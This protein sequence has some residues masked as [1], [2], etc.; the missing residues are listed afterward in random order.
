MLS[1][2]AHAEIP[3]RSFQCGVFM[4]RDNV[5]LLFFLLF[6]LYPLTAFSGLIGDPNKDDQVMQAAFGIQGWH[7]QADAAWQISFP[8]RSNA[9]VLGRIESELSFKKIDSP[10][11]VFRGGGKIDP[12]FS[13]D[14]L[15]GF[16]SIS[17][18]HGVDSDRFMPY[19]G[20][21]LEFSQS[22]NRLTGDVKTRSAV[23]FRR[24]TA[25]SHC[26]RAMGPTQ[27]T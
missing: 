7:A 12:R 13:F 17:G 9:G 22:R 14:L 19:S 10:M 24:D 16:G 15:Y 11:L 21:G 1:N 20:E 2:E 4:K 8:Y 6:F 25:T 23:R 27:P 18:G 5:L 3:F 26:M